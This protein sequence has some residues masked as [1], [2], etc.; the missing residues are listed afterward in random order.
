[1][2]DPVHRIKERV[3]GGWVF[4]AATGDWTYRRDGELFWRQVALPTRQAALDALAGE[5]ADTRAR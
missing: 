3:E 4:R 1:M 5:E 2:L